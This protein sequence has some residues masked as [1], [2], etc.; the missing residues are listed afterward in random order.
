MAASLLS[1]I[2][3]LFCDRFSLSF[4]FRLA[5]TQ[6]ASHF[7]FVSF[8]WNG[9]VFFITSIWKI[10]KHKERKH[11]R[12]P[13]SQV[14]TLLDFSVT[15]RE[16]HKTTVVTK[17]AMCYLCSNHTEIHTFQQKGK[18]E[19]PIFRFWKT[20]W[21]LKANLRCLHLVVQA[22]YKGCWSQKCSS[23]RRIRELTTDRMAG[24]HGIAQ[25]VWKPPFDVSLP[26]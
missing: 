3:L 21:K 2:S 18:C 12:V 15:C 25:C 8:L 5:S 13:S 7:G 17:K 1:Q 6:G 16:A 10:Q 26:G 19:R 14:P 23:M 11:F 20:F 9:T 24:C 4:F 22:A